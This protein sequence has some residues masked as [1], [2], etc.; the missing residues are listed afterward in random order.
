MYGSDTNVSKM[1]DKHVILSEWVN[2]RKK[3]VY[4][5]E[6]ELSTGQIS[7]VQKPACCTEN[8]LS[9]LKETMDS[10]REEMKI[11]M[12]TLKEMKDQQ[13]TRFGN[14]EKDMSDIK[15]T[16][17][18]LQ[19]TNEVVDDSLDYLGKKCSK[20][21]NAIEEANNCGIQDITR[22]AVS[23]ERRTATCIDHVFVRTESA[24]EVQ[25]YLL[26]SPLADHYLTGLTAVIG[27]LQHLSRLIV[28]SARTAVT[29]SHKM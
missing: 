9:S 4:E 23:A 28:T 15:I 5:S 1:K 17:C 6:G 20:L 29:L 12:H 16:I 7:A 14:F 11:M 24:S 2:P 21:E 27:A 25:A 3:R 8:M 26:T 22:E 18:Q 13:E 10:L 19:K